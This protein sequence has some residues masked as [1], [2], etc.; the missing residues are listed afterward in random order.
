ME[1][2]LSGWDRQE[3]YAL[4]ENAL[5]KLFA[6]T[7]PGNTDINEVLIKVSALNDFYST[8]IFSTV[9]VAKHML[10]L[11][12]DARLQAGD[13][14]L[15]NDLAGV[16][17]ADGSRKNFYSFATKYCSHHRPLDFPIYDSYVDQL[18]RY[19]RDRDGFAEFK[20]DRLKSY[21]DFKTILLKFR[22][23][24]ALN[25]Y[26]LKDITRYLWQLGKEKFP[27]KY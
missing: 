27:K 3:K 20:N 22:E 5:H 21:P 14:T 13:A 9:Q 2:Y 18:L 19:F 11:N 15:V 17:M 16:T 6:G 1:K 25:P 10:N 23:F 12:I 26:S 7:Y 24:Y 8:N 4:Q